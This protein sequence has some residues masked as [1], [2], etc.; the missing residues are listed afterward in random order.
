MRPM[1]DVDDAVAALEATITRQ[2]LAASKAFGGGDT[3]GAQIRSDMFIETLADAIADAGGLGLGPMLRESM[4]GDTLAP[5]RAR[6]VSHELSA[7]LQMQKHGA[8]AF[9]PLVSDGAANTSGVG[10]NVGAAAPRVSSDFGPRT[11]PVEGGSRFHTGVD[12]AV[13]EGTPIKAALNGVVKAAGPRGAYGNAV[14]IDH[15]NGMTTLYAH[16]SEVGVTA[17]QQVRAGEVIAAAGQTGRATGAH[18]HLEVRMEG[19]PINPRS[20]LNAYRIRVE[21]TVAATSPQ[22]PKKG[23]LP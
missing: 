21:D 8:V 12:L 20:A 5:G 14:E 6:D 1:R 10:S 15:G 9:S 13:P 11:D 22:S 17:G 4:G 2:L 18:L 16:N 23:D 3:P 19:K 7:G